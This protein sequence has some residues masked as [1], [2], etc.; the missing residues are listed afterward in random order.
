MRAYSSVVVPI[1]AV[2][3]LAGC[4]AMPDTVQVGKEEFLVY[5]NKSRS[6]DPL[7]EFV[8]YYYKGR[9]DDGFVVHEYV[10][11]QYSTVATLT[12]R[13]VLPIADGEE[14]NL[15]T[16]GHPGTSLKNHSFNFLDPPKSY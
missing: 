5:L 10:L 3:L 4:H 11:E 6:Q 9:Q 15:S 16:E 12:R 7:R 8:T 2:V 1:V 13:I 14:L